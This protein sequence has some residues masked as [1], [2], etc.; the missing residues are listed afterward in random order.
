VATNLSK[1]FFNPEM[2]LPKEEQGQKNGT[3][4]EGQAIRGQPQLGIN[5][6]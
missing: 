4:T 3:E 6:V 2:F 1:S 5:D